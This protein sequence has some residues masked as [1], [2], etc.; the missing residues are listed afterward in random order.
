MSYFF[1]NTEL[2]PMPVRGFAPAGNRGDPNA[3]KTGVDNVLS[4]FRDKD[5]VWMKLRWTF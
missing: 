5:E 1:G 3:Y 4:N 2:R